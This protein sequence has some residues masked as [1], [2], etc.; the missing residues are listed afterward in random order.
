MVTK[1]TK[2]S[3]K[4]DTAQRQRTRLNKMKAIQKA[5]LYAGGQAIE[6]LNTRLMFWENQK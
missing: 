2:G 4:S 3:R 1:P 5:L 6:K